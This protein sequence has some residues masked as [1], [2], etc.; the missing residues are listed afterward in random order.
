LPS[1]AAATILSVAMRAAATLIVSIAA[2]AL[3][4]AIRAR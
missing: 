4:F 1:S 2:G 3:A